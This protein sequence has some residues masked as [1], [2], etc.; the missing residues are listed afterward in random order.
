MTLRLKLLLAIALT[1]FAACH[2][3]AIY[4]VEA[5]SVRPSVEIVS[6]LRD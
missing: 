6:L 4:K 2:V 5:S 1:A 3:V